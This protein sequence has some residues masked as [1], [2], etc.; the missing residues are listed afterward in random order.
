V[1]SARQDPGRRD[2]R[3]QARARRGLI[4]GYEFLRILPSPRSR[5]NAFQREVDRPLFFQIQRG[6][7]AT[8][9]TAIAPHQAYLLGANDGR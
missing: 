2:Q 7:D 1:Q 8:E 4:G 3:R 5:E 6:H 9:P